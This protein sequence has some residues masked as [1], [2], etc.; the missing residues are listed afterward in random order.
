MK[1]DSRALSYDLLTVALHLEVGPCEIFP[2]H[3]DN[4]VLGHLPCFQLFS[5]LWSFFC[6]QLLSVYSCFNYFISPYFFKIL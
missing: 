3:I 1:T 2:T 6:I 5:A 4:I